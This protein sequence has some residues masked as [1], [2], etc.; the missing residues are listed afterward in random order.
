MLTADETYSEWDSKG[1][2]TEHLP[3]HQQGQNRYYNGPAYTSN[4]T[5]I[6]Q[7]VQIYVVH[8]QTGHQAPLT[9]LTGRCVTDH[10]GYCQIGHADREWN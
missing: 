1:M 5:V 10:I 3:Q 2:P 9:W 4:C 6:R 7:F 8:S